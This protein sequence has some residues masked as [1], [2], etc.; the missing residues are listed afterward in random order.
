[1]PFF[2]QASSAAGKVD[3]V[4]II[5]TAL[6]VAFLIFI[7]STIIFFAIKYNKK[8]HPKGED[9]EGKVW[10]EITWTVI[11]LIL[12]MGM[13]YYGWTNFDYTRQ[14]PRDAMA[15]NVTA[16]Q[17]AW[18][19][20]YPNG[21]RTSELMVAL[22]K[23]VKVNL[24]SLDVIHGFYVPALRIKEDV[25]PGKDNYTWFM[26]TR[27]GSFDIE[28]TVNCGLGHATMLSKVVVVQVSEFEAWYFGDEE[29]LPS[30]T[31]L[32]S[33]QTKVDSQSPAVAIL[34][35]KSCLTCHSLDGKVMVGPTFSGMCGRTRTIVANGKERQVKCDEAYL[36]R[37]IQSPMVE[38]V[39]GYP[40]TM[41]SNPLNT[42]N[43]KEVVH[44]LLSLK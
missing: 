36:S 35:S 24:H 32:A 27:L 12:F 19:F 15:I 26:P 42:K 2:Q 8:R 16:R 9:I 18:S 23:P 13:F 30:T 40:V 1:M 14:V 39:K 4:F 25:V 10:L 41:P 6:C 21:K 34:E 43:L 37:A 38:I 29:S 11:P 31:I 17:W 44:F 20:T 28:C 7:T 22:G 33:T 3:T 5:I